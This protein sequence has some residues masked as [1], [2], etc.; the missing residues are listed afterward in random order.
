MCSICFPPAA[1]GTVTTNTGNIVAD[2]GAA[3]PLVD[4]DDMDQA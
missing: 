2:P 1:P 4:P 3:F